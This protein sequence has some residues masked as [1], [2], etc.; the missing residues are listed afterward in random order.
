MRQQCLE[1]DVQVLVS[2]DATGKVT[3]ASPF[4]ES[5]HPEFNESATRAALSQRWNPAIQDGHAIS[6]VIK[7]SY[8]FRLAPGREQWPEH[9]KGSRLEVT[10]PSNKPL[11]LTIP[12]P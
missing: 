9:C 3:A 5:L 2:I 1:A 6:S 11:Q 7:Y 8:R 12:P 10:P 4:K